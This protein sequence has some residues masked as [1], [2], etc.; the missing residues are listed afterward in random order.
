MSTKVRFYNYSETGHRSSECVRKNSGPKC[1][2]CGEFGHVSSECTLKDDRATNQQN[3][4][5]VKK[6]PSIPVRIPVKQCE[7][8]ERFHVLE[9]LWYFKKSLIFIQE[10]YF[11]RQYLAKRSLFK[12]L[13]IFE[14]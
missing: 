12:F 10:L 14:N 7:G 13:W 1:F 9:I 6:L 3:V 2:K 8:C 4:L 11:V 5:L